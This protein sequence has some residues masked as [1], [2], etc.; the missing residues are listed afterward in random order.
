[1]P[2]GELDRP[3]VR[4]EGLDQHA[5]GRVA[6]AAARELGEQ[7]ERALLGPEVGQR[8]AGVGVDDR[9]QRD[10]LEVV[11]LRD[12]LRAEQHRP[13]G[14]GEPLERRGRVARVGVEPDQ[15]ELGQ[16]RG[17]LAL[18]PLR[19]GAEPGELGRAALGAELGRRLARGRSGGSEALRR[20]ALRSGG[21]AR[22]RSSGS[23][24]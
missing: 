12:H 5:P 23:G 3:R 10:A 2:G 7:L 16:P 8:E 14:G 17:E 1:M 11:A 4:L 21:R 24:G 22:R 9:G 15:L 18:E 6:A 13:V 19:A 20:A